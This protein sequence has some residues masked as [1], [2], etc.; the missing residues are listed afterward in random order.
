MAHLT[1][2]QV[3]TEI[4]KNLFAVLGMVTAKNEARTVGI[5]YTVHERELYISTRKTRGRHGISRRTTMCP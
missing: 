5:V 3:W 1:T 4:E 2:D